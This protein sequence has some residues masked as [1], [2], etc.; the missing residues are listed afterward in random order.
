MLN[1]DKSK[2][3]NQIITS[4]HVSYEK[5]THYNT[6]NRDLCPKCSKNNIENSHIFNGQFW[7]IDCL[8]CSLCNKLIDKEDLHI[9]DNFI[10]HKACLDNVYAKR[11]AVCTYFIE[12]D[13]EVTAMGK[14]YHAKCFR[15]TLCGTS[16]LSKFINIY[17]F[18]Y[19]KECTRKL[20]SNFASCL[21]CKKGIL[22][23][24]KCIDFFYAGKKY[25]IHTEC[26]SCQFCSGQVDNP[27]VADNILI[28]EKC[29]KFGHKHLC[30]AC[31]K[32]VFSNPATLHTLVFHPGCF[33]CYV[34]K[35]ILQS[36]LASV[37][38]YKPFCRACYTDFSKMCYMCKE[39]GNVEVSSGLFSFHKKCF[40]CKF[41]DKDLLTKDHALCDGYPVCIQCYNA[42]RDSGAIDKWN[43]IMG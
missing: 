24:D 29:N 10:F 5:L 39:F 2:L 37:Y 33:K 43:R 20:R 21:V 3:I 36:N 4:K 40:C 11:C 38:K 8:V 17:E 13:N 6:S 15:C 23:T 1:S 12:D 16:V 14:H 26:N 30:G 18:P 34:C 19:C 7:H 31:G 25:F 27:V 42:K 9:R 35:K 32:P 41:C 28:C 22:P